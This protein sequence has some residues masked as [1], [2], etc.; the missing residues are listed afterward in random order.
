MY[1]EPNQ[2]GVYSEKDAELVEYNSRKEEARIALLQIADNTW[3]Y[4]VHI[5]LRHGSWRGFS[6]P[7]T[8]HEVYD[9][10]RDALEAGLNKVARLAK[11]DAPEIARW[12]AEQKAALN[13]PVQLDL[14]FV[15][16][17]L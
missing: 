14:F 9:S 5:Q 1:P 10:R 12:V 2:Y 15:G 11:G 13:R 3:I 4:S 17:L 8:K 16:A 7:L 6:G